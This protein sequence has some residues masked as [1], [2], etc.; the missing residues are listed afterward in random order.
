MKT[1]TAKER[2]RSGTKQISTYKQKAYERVEERELKTTEGHLEISSR[3]GN[4]KG[5][6]S[7]RRCI[8]VTLKSREIL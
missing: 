8:K 6:H 4:S 5:R 3:K 7:I 2:G 1:E